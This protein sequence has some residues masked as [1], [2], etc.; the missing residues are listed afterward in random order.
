MPMHIGR[1]SEGAHEE[2]NK[3]MK[4]HSLSSSMMV[5]HDSSSPNIPS[6]LAEVR[7][8]ENSSGGSFPIIS[9]MIDTVPQRICEASSDG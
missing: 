1:G 9:S 4:G 6:G 3:N 2:M 8:T 7:V 5:T